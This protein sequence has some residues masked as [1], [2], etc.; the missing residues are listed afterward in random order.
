MENYNATPI[1][2][3]TS[4]LAMETWFSLL[5]LELTL[6]VVFSQQLTLQGIQCRMYQQQRQQLWK[7]K[8]I[9]KR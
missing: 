4:K 2:L 6:Y 8:A 1:D 3:K 7:H 5:F 9:H